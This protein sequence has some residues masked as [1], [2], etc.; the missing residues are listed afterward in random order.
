MDRA[1]ADEV[2]NDCVKATFI[3]GDPGND[4]PDTCVYA[5]LHLRNLFWLQL[6]DEDDEPEEPRR[7]LRMVGYGT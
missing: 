4:I 7:E 5:W 3:K 1:W 2:I 6:D